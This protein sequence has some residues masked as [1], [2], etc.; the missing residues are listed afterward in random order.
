MRETEF[1][2]K[3]AFDLIPKYLRNKSAAFLSIL[4]TRRAENLRP[5][6]CTSTAQLIIIQ[7]FDLLETAAGEVMLTYDDANEVR[8]LA[9]AHGFFI[10]PI[11]MKTT[12]HTRM[13][14]LAITNRPFAAPTANESLRLLE[15][16]PMPIII[17]I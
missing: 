10:K 14:E 4:P 8:D 16:S 12:H 5:S 13:Y 9:T 11:A 2:H 6:G 15:R 1:L 17:S 3:D 7:F